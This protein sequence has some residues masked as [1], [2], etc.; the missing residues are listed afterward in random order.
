MRRALCWAEGECQ[1]LGANTLLTACAAWLW[2]LM[3]ETTPKVERRMGWVWGEGTGD[4][5]CL[6]RKRSE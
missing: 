3:K 1:P 4:G 6:R 5:G 2:D